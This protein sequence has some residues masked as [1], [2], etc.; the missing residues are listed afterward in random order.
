LLTVARLL[1]VDAG[2]S[3]IGLAVGDEETGL[4]FPFAII[5]RRG[6]GLTWSAEAVAARAREAGAELVVVGLP[7]NVDGSAGLQVARARA[8]GRRIQQSTGLPV[9]YWDER[10]S[11][12]I[13]EQRATE[14]QTSRHERMVHADHLAA[15]VILQAYLDAGGEAAT[16]EPGEDGGDREGKETK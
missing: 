1:A 9:R 8:L 2:E 6:R 7:L 16:C 11:T 14:L 12:F 5:E 13:A 3:R 4:A 15:S 10:M